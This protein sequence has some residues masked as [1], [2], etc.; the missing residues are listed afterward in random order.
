MVMMDDPARHLD[1]AV[2]VAGLGI[3]MFNYEEENATL[4]ERAA[5]LFDLEPRKPVSR[6]ALHER[7]HPDDQAEVFE[8]ISELLVPNGCDHIDMVHRVCREDGRV[9]WLSSRKQV[10]FDTSPDDPN[11]RPVSGLMAVLD[12]TEHRE[13]EE[14]IQFLMRELNHRSKNLL[15]VI[16]GVARMTARSSE[17]GD[18]LKNFSD[19]LTS[20]A[21]NQDV[22]VNGSWREADLETLVEAQ[23]RPFKEEFGSRFKTS[24]PTVK[25]KADA[26]QAISM[27]VHELATNA[28]KYGA[29]SNDAGT[30]TIEWSLKGNGEGQLSL[31]WREKGGPEVTPPERQGFGKRVIEDMTA[32]S[33]RGTVVYDF[34]PEGVY[35]RLDVPKETALA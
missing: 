12:I 9:I 30:V 5:E 7:I 21:A 10:V 25:L 32:K 3:V 2:K 34:R 1:I 35:W 24:G 15:S 17:A 8:K 6:A 20:L 27:A 11:A 13:A 16:D 31:E 33:L 29:L 18:F 23:I 4:D 28:C 19:R 26:A 14:R 22:L